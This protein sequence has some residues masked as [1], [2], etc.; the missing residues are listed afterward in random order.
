MPTGYTKGILDGSITSFS[1]F[2]QLCM[3]AFDA[4]IHMRDSHVGADWEPR[5]PSEYH[6]NEIDKA[7]MII[8]DCLGMT[9][10]LILR[11]ERRR[12]KEEKKRHEDYICTANEQRQRLNE[13]LSSVKGW[14]PPTTEHVGIKNFMIEQINSTID[15]DCDTKYHKDQI[16]MI[17]TKLSSICPSKVRAELMQKAQKDIAYHQ[18]E[19]AKE[20]ER[21]ESANKW[22]A[23]LIKSLI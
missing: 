21:C 12:L 3:R 14:E 23:D 13:M 2:A 11:K 1:Q 17:D 19:Y 15:F 22:V 7:N 5:I 18:Q 20:I 16:A 8:Q 4:T 6:K 9:D 10:K